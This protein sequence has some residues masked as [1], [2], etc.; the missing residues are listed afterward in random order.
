MTADSG[1]I[2]PM[3]VSSLISVYVNAPKP[4]ASTVAGTPADRETFE[5]ALENARV[6]ICISFY[7][8]IIE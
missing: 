8:G 1:P 4:A 5:P 6:V 7:F 2:I 3:S